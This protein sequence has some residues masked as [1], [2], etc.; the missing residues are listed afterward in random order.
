MALDLGLAVVV[1]VIGLLGLRSGA[2]RQLSHW[3]ALICAY[4]LSGPLA[5]W[6]TP[7]VAT[8]LGFSPSLVKFGLSALFFLAL[9][10]TANM[11]VHRVLGGSHGEREGG[12]PDRF[13][14]FILGTGKGAVFAYALLCGLLSF[15]GPLTRA[16]GR[17][18]AS[19]DGSNAVAF[20]R[21][22][23]LFAS[24]AVPAIARLEKLA[25]A[26]KDPEA[27]RAL[28]Q[29]AQFKALLDDPALKAAVGDPALLKALETGDVSGL[30]NDPRFKALLDDPRLNAAPR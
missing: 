28:G 6:A 23:N 13:F 20:A 27:A 25:A 3:A 26:A 1:L 9:S 4:L 15:E 24:I 11:A 14:G 18:P 30:K 8:R 16:F 2:I 5:V 29:D 10:I 12:R 7:A 17:P 21:A 22:H 19:F